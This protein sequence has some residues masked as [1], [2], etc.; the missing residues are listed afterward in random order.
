MQK[1]GIW[2][3]V[4][5]VVLL[6]LSAFINYS[7][8][9]N[10]GLDVAGG[11]RFTIRAE[12]GNLSAE[13]RTGEAWARKANQTVQILER[14]AAQS[15]GV[16]EANVYRK[17]N[18][19]FI[20]ELPGVSNEAEARAIL[21]A[22]ARLQYFWPRNVATD[23]DIS[24]PYVVEY[25]DERDE[26]GA[27]INVE[28]FRRRTTT[29]TE[30]IEPKSEEWQ[31]MLERWELITTGDMLVSADA[32]LGPNNR[33]YEILLQ[34]K[35]DGAS[36][37]NQFAARHVSRG[38]FL[39][40]VMDD[41]VV[42]FARIEDGVTQ[43]TGGQVVL[44]GNFDAREANRVASLLNGGALPVDLVEENLTKVLPSIGRQ[45]LSQ[46]LL[47]GMI[48]FALIAVFLIAYYLFAGFVALLALI[49]YVSLSYAAFKLI[50]VTFSLAAIAGFILSI[51]MAVDANI[52][53]FERIKEELREGKGLLTSIELGF[54]RAFPAILDS[55]ACTILTSAVLMWIGT[56]PVKGFATTLL[57]GVFI[58]LFTAVMVTRALLLMFTSLGIA[59]N[60]KLYGV[61]RSWFG[62]KWEAEA[63]EKP[64]QIIGKM[65]L[66]F[67]IS[68]LLI[69]PGLI[70][71]FMGGIKPNVEFLGGIESVVRLPDGSA[72]SA[73]EISD[74]VEAAGFQGANV[75]I[76][77]PE[78][79][80]TRPLA[81]I[82]IPPRENP[83]VD[84]YFALSREANV[85]QARKELQDLRTQIGTE[86]VTAVGANA[87]LNEQGA[88]TDEASFEST[89]PAVREET[90]RGA[91]IGVIASSVLIVL[92][93]SLRFGLALGGF[94][95]GL[96]FGFSA[97]LA[98]LHDV[99]I[100]IGLSAIFG[101]LFN[102]EVSQL[103][104]TAMLTVIGF[105]VHDTIV[106]FDRIRENL[107][108]PIAGEPFDRLV[109]RSI[110]QSIARS[111]NTGG[112]VIL[113][114]FILVFWGSATP[115]LKHF[116]AIMLIGILAGTFS[117]IFNASPILVLW[118]R[119]VRNR[120]GDDATILHD[121]AKKKPKREFD[122]DEEATVWRDPS[123]Q[124]SG[125]G[126]VRRKKK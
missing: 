79:N 41:E 25:I 35:S 113:T 22:S 70:A 21:T 116:N 58:S 30:Y 31:R 84:R 16:S 112:I 94:V 62:E 11:V 118:E 44:T 12:I 107:Q 100:I 72:M 38:E 60:P 32:R 37:L 78:E 104:I 45:A 34:F 13:E 42:S 93:L 23:R 92:W 8:D 120:K 20:V 103:T 108:R 57:I 4:V 43:F 85:E 26:T 122:I 36:A 102:W 51:G 114:L 5:T 46:I 19:K 10:L 124:K 111:L 96:R 95:M 15:L 115:D 109:D 28:K 87:S 126:Q 76:G 77:D 89:G 66:Y 48:S 56:G 71:V 39:A 55:N 110:T 121:Q 59:K 73:Q 61:G 97:I 54:K 91:I 75:K 9:P 50:G 105:S 2:F 29:D 1:R 83:E 106:I 7:E 88:I 123:E 33:N 117:S 47:A 81:Y 64:L 6:G 53:I 90:I 86:I 14:R 65:K 3:F 27:T 24:R 63:N 49:A 18:D 98:M 68:G 119:I 40:A 82:T 101:L 69:V 67:L 52:L 125:Y 99:G 80:S 17:G 74:K